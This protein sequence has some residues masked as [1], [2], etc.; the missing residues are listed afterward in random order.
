MQFMIR[1]PKHHLIHRLDGRIQRVSDLALSK[2][3]ALLFTDCLVEGLVGNV[4]IKPTDSE[5]ILFLFG[6]VRVDYLG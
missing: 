4:R 5:D 3:K 2:E 1:L 6:T